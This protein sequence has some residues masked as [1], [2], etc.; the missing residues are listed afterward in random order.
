MVNSAWRKRLAVWRN[1]FY[2]Y[3]SP[4]A[5]PHTRAFWLATGLV[6]LL[7]ILFAGYF[8]FYLTSLQDAY[9]TNAEDLGMMD[10]AI[11]STLH[12][13][14]L[15]QT[16]CNIIGDTNCYTPAGISRL[17]IH[18]EPMLFPVSLLYSIWPGPK[19]L[20]V[21]Q[22]LVVASGAYPAF[23][24]ARLRLRNE[25]ASVAIALLYLLYPAQ[26]NALVFDFHAVTFTSALLLFALY[27]MYTRRTAWLFVFALLA[28]ACKEEIPLIVACFGLWSML[29]QHR[30]R[31]GLLLVLLALIW[32]VLGL[33]VI[34][35]FSPLGHSHLIARY[36][37]LGSNPLQIAHTLLT[38]PLD[39]L[40]QH[41]LER[42]HFTYLSSLFAPAGY[43]PLFAPWVLVLAL[44]T[45]LLNLF[46]TDPGMYSGIFQYNAELVP[47]L[48]FA[49][50]EAMVLLLWLTKRL[51]HMRGDPMMSFN[52]IIRMLEPPARA[53]KSAA[54]AINRPLRWPEYFVHE[55]YCVPRG[56]NGRGATN[57]WGCRGQGEGECEGKGQGDRKGRP[58]NM[59]KWLRRLQAGLLLLLL[60][61]ILVG[62]VHEDAYRSGMPLARDFHWPQVTAHTML[63]Q[64]FIAMV[65]PE[66]SVSSQSKLV[67]HMSQRL[68]I[69]MFPYADTQADYIL[70]DLRGDIYPYATR[71]AYQH[72]VNRVLQSG[73]YRI[74]A[75]QDGYLLLKRALP[76][77]H[78]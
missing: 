1:R 21:L 14:L 49:T 56:G 7:V 34:H 65:P 73:N 8:I 62:V 38:H 3:P 55:H 27:F 45:L 25:W 11:W 13:H 47:I 76:L 36:S 50:I 29:L 54:G 5:L 61:F 71:Q 6:T 44:P 35:S 42:S 68:N 2:L 51:P 16:I 60:V 53:D 75:A 66:A 57:G 58:Y 59:T 74:L 18:F 22:T 9:L 32:T 64:H 26:Q 48:I 24:L 10:Q 37:Y 67:P 4:E 31:S 15:H 63:A 77:I 20:Q 52:K 70:L 43:L 78:Y 33:L 72:E 39:M 28:M 12:G 23:W 30:W 41:V 19:S 46:S 17:A 40:K 69:Y